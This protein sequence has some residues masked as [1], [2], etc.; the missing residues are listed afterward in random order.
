MTRTNEFGQP[1]GDPLDG[2]FPRPRPPRTAMEGRYCSLVPL[3]PDH[4]AAL[5]A[6]YAS[7]PDARGWTYL[8]HGPFADEDSYAA[9]VAD[10]AKSEDPLFFTVLAPDDRPLG[11]ASFLRIDPGAGVIE[12]G[13]INFSHLMQRSRI[14]TEAMFLMMSRAFD[15]LGYRR[16]E[17]KCDALNAPSMAAAN[18]LGFN[19]EGTFRQATHYKGR[20]RD[21]AWFSIIDSEWP[22]IR[23]AFIAW[24]EPENFET[25][26]GQ[27]SP[28]RTK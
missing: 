24:L 28:L 15:E 26:G 9:W 27:K 25:G 22:A 11:T 21:T 13:F 20:N 23:D 8:P 2:A 5:H 17:W 19:Y 18:R 14:S 4:A 6:A 1:I 12:V 3:L 7:A 16:Y 10:A